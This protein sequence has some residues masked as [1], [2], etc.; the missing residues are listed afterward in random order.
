MDT[1][2][3]SVS[4]ST[5]VPVPPAVVFGLL[6]DPHQHPVL[7]GSGTVKAVVDAPDRLGPDAVFRMRMGGYTTTNTVIEYAEDALIAWR[8]RARHVWRWTLEPVDA[9]TRVTE[10]FD[11]SAKRAPRVVRA[12]GIPTRA[13]RALTATLDGLHDRFALAPTR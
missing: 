13:E 7:D 12:L 5:V 9:G 3:R 6:T 11:W 1:S 10:T 8:H 2:P 4:R